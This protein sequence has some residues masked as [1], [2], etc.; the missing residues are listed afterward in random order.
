[1]SALLFVGLVLCGLALIA[2]AVSTIL[3]LV[4]FKRRNIED[5]FDRHIILMIIGAVSGLVALAGLGCIVIHFLL[6]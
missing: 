5:T 2:M 6:K 1:M 3:S 4:N